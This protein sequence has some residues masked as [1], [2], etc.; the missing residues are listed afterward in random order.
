MCLLLDTHPSFNYASDLLQLIVT[1]T[2]HK[3]VGVATM[4]CDAVEQL[5]GSDVLGQLSLE[6]VQLVADV[7]KRRNCVACRPRVLMCLY[8][9]QIDALQEPVGMGTCFCVCVFVCVFLG[10]CFWVCVFEC[11]ARFHALVYY[12]YLWCTYVLVHNIFS[13]TSW[14]SLCR[15]VACT[16]MHILD[17]ICIFSITHT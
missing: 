1:N 14:S 3:D 5:L 9:L 12:V 10:V 8:A 6:A 7:I 13:T 4:C 17:H 2:V 15:H 16:H 11:V